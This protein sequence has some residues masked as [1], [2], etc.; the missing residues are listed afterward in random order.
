[1]ITLTPYL[2]GGIL[3]RKA[4]GPA[5]ARQFSAQGGTERCRPDSGCIEAVRR[6]CQALIRHPR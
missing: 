4:V 2:P 1:M 3:L 6:A 5:E